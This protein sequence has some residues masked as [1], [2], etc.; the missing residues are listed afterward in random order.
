[1]AALTS[2]PHDRIRVAGYTDTT[3][4]D[5]TNLRLSDQRAEAVKAI[6]RERG[7]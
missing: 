7:V 3:G 1:M 2:Y 6:L 5:E 4:S